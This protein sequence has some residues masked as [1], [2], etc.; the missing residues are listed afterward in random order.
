MSGEMKTTTLDAMHPRAT[1]IALIEALIALAVILAGTAAI[2]GLHS[3]VVGSSAESRLQSAAMG[4]AQA[5][6]EEFRT[7]EFGALSVETNSEAWGNGVAE[8]IVTSPGLGGNITVDLTRCW[9]IAEEG[10]SGSLLRVQVSVVRTGTQC[11]PGAADALAS[12]QTLIAADDR[13]FA[14]LNVEEQRTADGDGLVD[15]NFDISG[16]PVR[17]SLPGGFE[18]IVD[19]E[20]RV[21]ALIN[22][23]T[24]SGDTAQA[25]KA[26]DDGALKFAQIN[27]N[28]IFDSLDSAATEIDKLK[29][30]AEG[31]A[32]CRVDYPGYGLPTDV[33][34]LDAPS[35]T[36]PDGLNDIGFHMVRYSCVVADQWRRAIFLSKNSLVSQPPTERVCVGHPG[37]AEF[38]PEA[39][40]DVLLSRGRQYTGRAWT[41]SNKDA[42]KRVGVRGEPETT[43][44]PNNAIFGS[45]CTSADANCW[46]DDNVSLLSE[47]Q[48]FL[49]TLVPGGHHFFLTVQPSTTSCAEAM[50]VLASVDDVRTG[51]LFFNM[52]AR[53]PDR[54]YC[55]N[56]KDYTADL[57]V[58]ATLR[59]SE[60]CLS[61]TRVS[62]FLTGDVVSGSGIRITS[63]SD[64]RDPCTVAGEFNEAGGGYT[65]GL[66]EDAEAGSISARYS[67]LIANPAS[68][69]LPEPMDV[70]HDVV[71]RNFHFEP[72]S[73]ADRCT[74]LTVSGA[75]ASGSTVTMVPGSCSVAGTTYS[76][77]AS[78]IDAGTRVTV[79]A[80]N[81]VESTYAFDVASGSCSVIHDFETTTGPLT[82][83]NL[84]VQGSRAANGTVS[85]VGLTCTTPASTRYECRTG[86][87]LDGAEF[88]I[89]H[90]TPG[91][92]NSPP[93][94]RTQ[95]V[96][97]SVETAGEPCGSIT[98]DF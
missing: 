47:K 91:P 71:T 73:A 70:A 65:C 36:V 69:A 5:T 45:V 35:V 9:T 60:D 34:R 63:P 24:I 44:V 23:D 68:F 86:E 39:T 83:N 96:L 4:V 89:R 33:G 22:P 74:T 26:K 75:V 84:L 85:S 64:Y 93:R 32:L 8:P 95:S 54:V 58:D 90:Q 14:A 28:I 10:D 16:H 38:L 3:H 76:C 11:V 46:I 87:A 82:C 92:G 48:R 67:G 29:V 78:G 43:S 94:V 17:D 19:A 20:G 53:N 42:R 13:R 49:R 79:S 7:R 30:Q 62:G 51:T 31:A 27:G 88:T 98:V 80:S 37:L 52:L 61:F 50:S 81:G 66:N 41:D 1:G 12:L 2:F 25:L 72:G 21:I 6:L 18:K 15:P 55:T 57:L 59:T 97:I 40:T 56:E 77:S